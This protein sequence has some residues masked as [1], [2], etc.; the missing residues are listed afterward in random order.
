MRVHHATEGTNAA[1]LAEAL[2]PI[3][4][5]T[6]RLDCLVIFAIRGDE[7]L[8][9]SLG[10]L[11][12]SLTG[13]LAAFAVIG[14]YSRPPD[15][16]HSVAHGLREW[17]QPQGDEWI[18]WVDSP[19]RKEWALFRGIADWAKYVA[20]GA[21]VT[22]MPLPPRDREIVSVLRQRLGE[23]PR[24]D[25]N[26]RAPYDRSLWGR[27]ET[28]ATDEFAA[29]LSSDEG[30]EG[31]N[32]GWVELDPPVL[33]LPAR[34]RAFRARGLTS[35]EGWLLNAPVLE[36]IVLVGGGLSHLAIPDR[37]L[38]TLCRVVLDKNC[39]TVLP[40]GLDD[41]RITILSL[42]RNGFSKVPDG[43]RKMSRLE[44]LTIG[45]NP[46]AT[47]PEWLAEMPSLKAI[48]IGNLQLDSASGPVISALRERGVNVRTRKASL[49][50]LPI[51]DPE[52]EAEF[53]RLP[54]FR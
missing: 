28:A 34:L 15:A 53:P 22:Q 48:D 7:R 2:G 54:A 9:G 51:S 23:G 39:L 24:I 5:G 13:Q 37:T 1:R 6:T 40:N 18:A 35:L 10:P 4:A 41:A 52:F 21:L 32:L 25:L 50:G 46:I 30:M 16:S 3:L 19:V 49:G 27:L 8:P 44:S 29:V 43:I 12:G 17:A 38:S 20:D 26:D 31:L 33:R 11:L 45:A 47:L 36:E 14:D 42:Y